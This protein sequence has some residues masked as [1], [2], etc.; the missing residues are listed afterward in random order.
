MNLRQNKFLLGA[1]AW[2]VI[3]LS[4]AWGQTQDTSGNGLLKGNFAF[5]NVAV[6]NV[7]DD[8]NATEVTATYGTIVFDGNGN[9]TITGMQVDNVVSSTPQTFSATGTYAIGANG[10]GY[11][12][13]PLYPTDNTS[14]FYEYGAVSQGVFT[15]S[16]TEAG[17]Q[18]VVN[19]DIF[20]AIPTGSAPTNAS[21]TS[22]YQTGVLDF[23]GGTSTAINNALF[24][25][26]PNGKGGLAAITLNGQASN[27]TSAAVPLTQTITGAT[28]NFNSDG[29]ATLTVPLPSGATASTALF[30]GTKTIFQSAD[31]NFI[32]GWTSTG[33]DIFFG[34]KALAAGTGS[35]SISQGLYFTAAE[36]SFPTS[37]GVDS[38]YGSEDNTADT[39]GD[40]ILH[41]RLSSFGLYS[42]G[43]EDYGSDDSLMVNSDGTA[44]D[45][46]YN[47][48][49]GAGGQ[50]YVGVGLYGSGLYSLVVGMHAASF[51]GSG[52]YLNPIG[53]FNAA[54]YQPITASLAPGELIT[55]YGSGLSSTTMA[56]QGGQPAPTLGLGGVTAT[57][58]SIPC[59]VFA[60]SPGQV[61]IIVPYEITVQGTYLA[62][63]QV[64][65]NGVKSNVVQMYYQDSAPGAFSDTQ[66]GLGFAAVRDA[67]T[68][69]LI[70]QANP[71]QPNEYL[72]IYMTGLGTVTPPITDGAV[73]SLTTL[74][75]S[76][77]NT[78]GNLTVFF[79][80]Y[81]ADSLGNQ[82]TIQFAGLVPGLAGLYVINVQLPEAG[83]LGSGDIVELEFLTDS[84]DVNQIYIPY[85]PNAP[86][87]LSRPV[88]HLTAKSRAARAAAIRAARSK[89]KAKAGRG[90]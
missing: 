72:A 13:S 62:D 44:S 85:G 81:T 60:V 7:D 67:V 33:Y 36:E 15:G 56:I 45:Y 27:Q 17:S 49:F 30:T 2:A 32:L 68:G 79:N 9:Y 71:A 20:I 90:Q 35:N 54:S 40:A 53:V 61:S 83:V 88:K 48:A 59:P 31:G 89:M 37:W 80:D 3:G 39:N 77:E 12:T 42:N 28:Y 52:V 19:N 75:Y 65:N 64:T 38:Y 47:Y 24:N 66:N 73:P 8:N 34:V 23:S 74:S 18:G 11:V 21:F 84:A 82:G 1:A 63:I 55:M 58:N 78:L 70:D 29:S 14:F 6:T 26:S 5:R 16:T 46:F 57:I 51:S 86:T 41:Q 22:V 69:A 43:A 10:T 4:A 25:L 50:A 87:P 76:D